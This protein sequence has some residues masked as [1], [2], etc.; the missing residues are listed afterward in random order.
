MSVLPRGIKIKKDVTDRGQGLWIAVAGLVFLLALPVL[1]LFFHIRNL[2]LVLPAMLGAILI[3]LGLI[4]YLKGGGQPVTDER[5]WKI[6]NRALALS[7]GVTWVLL[8]ILPFLRDADLL[9]LSI[10]NI[11]YLT[12]FSMPLTFIAFQLYLNRK[13]DV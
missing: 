4:F 8:I 12:W 11:L 2:R 5:K 13:G 6:D 1:W 7:W 3:G 9:P 10:D